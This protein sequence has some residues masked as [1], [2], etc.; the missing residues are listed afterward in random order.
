MA[1]RR[2]LTIDVFLPLY[3]KAVDEGMTKED[4]ARKVGL[5]PATVYQRVYE[6][7]REGADLPLLATTSRR[8]IKDRAKSIISEY[9]S[10]KAKKAEPKAAAPVE[11]EQEL[12]DALADILR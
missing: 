6:L 9:Q 4:F 2:R 10:R 8:P 7:R 1:E 3:L 5:K 11:E 12:P